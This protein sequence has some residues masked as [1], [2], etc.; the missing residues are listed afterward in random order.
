MTSPAR[1]NESDQVARRRSALQV[2]AVVGIAT[3][4][5]TGCQALQ[6][7]KPSS[8]AK[9]PEALGPTGPATA[10]TDFKRDATPGQ[11]YNVHLEM[12]RM[13]ESQGNLEAAVAEYAKAA[14][15]PSKHAGALLS[16]GGKL[17][18]SS[19]ALAQRRMAGALDRLGRFAQAE[20][21][22]NQALKLAPRD[23]KIWN[24]VGYS[25]YLQNRWPDAERALKSAD[26]IEPNNP[27]V[28][29]NLGLAFAAQGKDDDA[30]A[31]LTRSGG[32]AVGHANLGFIFAA[33]GKNEE[34]RRQYQEAL[35]IQPRLT[36]AQAALAKLDPKAAQGAPTTAIANVAA[37]VRPIV[38]SPALA[39]I[40]LA[41]PAPIPFTP[42]P[43]PSDPQ[44]SLTAVGSREEAAI[45][46]ATLE[47]PMVPSRTMPDV[48]K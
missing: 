10:K 23:A 19:E 14:E 6:E 3:L 33:M 35:T 44:V 13:Y 16:D 22:Y 29:T 26:S 41:A 39:T 47:T 15:V 32:A 18:P 11:Q 28:L 1:R 36:A 31:A 34:A 17:G 25:Y 5:A 40:P 30:L 38:D 43:S 48:E 4:L 21:H 8:T 12:G 7:R 37:P 20:T 42:S 27:R 24:D 9:T 46:P 2:S 45:V